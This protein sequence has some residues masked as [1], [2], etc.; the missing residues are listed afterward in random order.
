MLSKIKLLVFVF[1]IFGLSAYFFISN[2]SYQNSIQAR[3]YYFLGNYDSAYELAKKAYEQDSYNKMANTVM[4]QSKIAKKYEIYIK[5]GNEYLKK[6]DSISAKK[7][8]SEA[9]KFRVKMMSEIMIEG[10]KDL[11]PSTLTDE[12]LIENSKKMQK[13]FIQLYKELF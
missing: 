10:Y 3:V 13:K 9:D 7:E 8:Y 12:S 4:T 11:K 5:Q 2:P 6:I 1:I